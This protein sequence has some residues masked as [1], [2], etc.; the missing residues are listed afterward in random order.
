MRS[1]D[2]DGNVIQ[3]RMP[4]THFGEAIAPKLRKHVVQQKERG[5]VR[6]QLANDRKGFCGFN[7]IHR[8][9]GLL[10][11][12]GLVAKVDPAVFDNRYASQVASPTGLMMEDAI[13]EFPVCV[14]LNT[15]FSLPD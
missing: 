11:D 1:E 9:P 5:R 14:T 2:Q 7:G 4:M 3:N 13:T 6:K 12:G 15:E 8:P 10:Q